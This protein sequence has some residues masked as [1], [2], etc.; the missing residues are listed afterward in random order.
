V[1]ILTRA[2]RKLRTEGPAA[3]SLAA[4]RRLAG[5][6]SRLRDRGFDRRLGTETSLFVETGA[7]SDVTS[8]NLAHGIRY[9]PTRA[10]P[11][12][13]LLTT[14]AIP[15]RGTFV[16]I[17]CGKGRVLMLAAEHGFTRVAGVDYSPSLCAIARRNLDILREKTGLGFESVIHNADASV[18]A[19]DR[20][21]TV[22][23]LYNPFDPTVLRAVLANLRASL[24]R[25]P[26]ELWLVYHRPEWR[27]VIEEAGVFETAGNF[28][29]GGCEFAVYRARRDG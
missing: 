19:F 15:A 11:F 22:V 27:S 12:Q 16:D 9:E 7:Q 10:R 5:A 23:F 26:R 8:A 29:F 17:G 2:I 4:R 20:D 1:S 6:V 25:D 14:A 18:Y 28:S 24:A 21:D 13:K 3:V